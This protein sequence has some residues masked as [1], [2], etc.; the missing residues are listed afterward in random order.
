MKKLQDWEIV[1]FSN[2]VRV[3][4]FKIR[5]VLDQIRGLRC[6]EALLILKFMSNRSCPIV[7]KVLNSAVANAKFK[8]KIEES[9]LRIKEVYVNPGPIL[10]RFRAH[11]QGRAFS[12]KKRMS[13][14]VT[15]F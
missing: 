13:H 11:A 4:P 3:S 7:M 2:Y 15:L 8:F 6:S 12:I 1:S 10:K 14:I 9:S 5:R